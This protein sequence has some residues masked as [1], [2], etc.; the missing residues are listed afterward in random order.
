MNADT[1][2]IVAN[3]LALLDD[4]IAA[5]LRKKLDQF[6]SLDLFIEN[7]L[8]ELGAG[9]PEERPSPEAPASESVALLTGGSAPIQEDAHH[10]VREA[11]LRKGGFQQKSQNESLI[12]ALQELR[13]R[14]NETKFRSGKIISSKA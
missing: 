5:E 12:R 8:Q 11:D 2:D 3:T 10:V 7:S 9:A 4:T 14:M 1:V 6:A 13:E